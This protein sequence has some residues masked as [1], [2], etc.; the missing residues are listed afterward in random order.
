MKS[1]SLPIHR[2]SAISTIADEFDSIIPFN[3][4]NALYRASAISTRDRRRR[5]NESSECVNALSRASAISTEQLIVDLLRSVQVLM[6]CLGLQPFLQR[7]RNK[8]V[9]DEIEC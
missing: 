3:G 5:N 1:P 8:R 7:I 4:V 6:P 2:A 9:V